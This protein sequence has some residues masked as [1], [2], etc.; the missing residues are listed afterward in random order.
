MPTTLFLQ[1]VIAIAWDF[2]KTLIPGYMQEPLF[3][4]YGIDAKTFWDEVRALPGY[5]RQHGLELVSPDSLYLNHILTYVRHGRCTGLTNAVLRELG[6]ELEFYPG[7]PAIFG[8]L[9]E[10]LA[11]HPGTQQHD[12]RLEHY[13]VSTGLRQM[14]LGSAVAKH[15]KYVWGCEFVESE[16]PPGFLSENVP[17]TPTGVIC[18]VGYALDNTTK[19]RAIFEINKGSNV[20][21]EIN[22]NSSIAAEDRRVPFQ[23]M[24]YVADGPSDVPVFSVVK[25]QGGRT[26]AVYPHGAEADLAQVNQLLREGRV[27]AFGEADFQ[28]GSQ[29][30]MWLGQAVD[31]IADRITEDRNSVLEAKVGKPPGH[32]T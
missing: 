12:I 10:R 4:R 1:N 21:P 28:T 2:D 23:N 18:Q 6:Q 8:A 16:P 22:V 7:V 30:A 32:I 25:S 17:V 3:R 27:L 31:A 29:T 13:I 5:Y 20:F 14:I 19:T 9:G 24:I 11:R 26:Y 15:V